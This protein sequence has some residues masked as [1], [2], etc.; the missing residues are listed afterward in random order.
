MKVLIAVV[1][2]ATVLPACTRTE[3]QKPGA[4]PEATQREARDCDRL[5]DQQA[6]SGWGPGARPTSQ[7]VPPSLRESE[8][9]RHYAQCMR[10]KGYVQVEAAD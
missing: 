7:A 3:W 4:T 8:Y 9:R 5:A 2:L 6:R 1:A 10:A